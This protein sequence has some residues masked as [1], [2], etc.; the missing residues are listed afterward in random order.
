MIQEQKK[1]NKLR[2]KNIAK[3]KAISSTIMSSKAPSDFELLRLDKIN[4]Y[5]DHQGNYITKTGH[6][7]DNYAIYN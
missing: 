6:K 3:G 7:I 5:T 1:H 2:R 4:H